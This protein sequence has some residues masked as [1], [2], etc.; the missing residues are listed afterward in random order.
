MKKDVLVW[1]NDQ[2]DLEA[3]TK[4][5]SYYEKVSDHRHTAPVSL[6]IVKS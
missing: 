4:R 2:C 3:D 6:E 5:V 1:Q